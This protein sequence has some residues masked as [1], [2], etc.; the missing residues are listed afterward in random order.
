M[1]PCCIY[2]DFFF[3]SSD[4]PCVFDCVFDCVFEKSSHVE[5]GHIIILGS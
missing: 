3:S 1:Y 5:G 2:R 4:V